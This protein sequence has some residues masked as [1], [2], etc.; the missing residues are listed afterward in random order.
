LVYPSRHN[1]QEVPQLL[2]RVDKTS[3]LAVLI[4]TFEEGQYFDQPSATRMFSGFVRTLNE[5]TKKN[6]ASTY[7]AID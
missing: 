4:F 7:I 3:D 2:L 5:Y 1:L 6:A